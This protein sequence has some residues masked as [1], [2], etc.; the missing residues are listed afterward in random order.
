MSHNPQQPNPKETQAGRL[1][2]YL[3][4]AGRLTRLLSNTPVAGWTL[5]WLRRIIP[6]PGLVGLIVRIWRFA[7]RSR[8]AP[9]KKD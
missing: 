9:G 7:T 2:R 6:I 4:L 1:R 5:T 8:K 3:M